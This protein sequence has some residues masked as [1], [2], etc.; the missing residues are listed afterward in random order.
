MKKS[1]L[2]TIVL[3]LAAYLVLPL[4]GLSSSLDS[5]IGK[6]R[7]QIAGKKA[8]EGV[9]TTQMAS[10]GVRI[11]SLRGDISELQVRENKVQRELDAKQAELNTIRNRR[12]IV[13]NRLVK[14]RTKLAKDRKLLA[15]RLVA[16]YKDQEPD[17]VTVVLEARGF[18]DLLDR[19]EYVDRISAQ[20]TSIVTRVR[21]TTHAVALDEKRLGILEGQAKAAA[22][23][24][25]V[26]RN[27]IADSK[28]TL[29]SR[30]NDLVDARDV[31]ARAVARIKS[32]RH[33]LEGNLGDL[34]AR[35]AKIQ[36]RLQAASSGVNVSAAGPIKQGSGNFI[37]PVNGPITSPFGG[38]NIGAGSEFHPGLDIGASTGTP[39]RAAAAG[40]ITLQQPESASGGYG[41]F[42][43]I[44]HTASISTCYGH[45]SKFIAHAGQH[46]SQGQVIGLVG[47]TG[48]CF[49]P[50]L[51]FEVRVNGAVTN[52]LNYL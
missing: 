24:I 10:Y 33:E 31:R 32:S 19:A 50:H 30:Q 49:G 44:Q 8:K 37:W 4:P 5:R 17:M 51:H 45:Q 16:L 27:E 7:D 46:V 34:E 48:R 29:V 21:D 12:Q 43:C 42:T 22:D 2:L 25:L 14:L 3:G 39:I 38:R 40:T 52:P 36:A 11:Q 1:F 35:Q 15:T 41:N 23:A 26:K 28:Q 13:Q 6:T 47:C 18:T 9:L 20:N